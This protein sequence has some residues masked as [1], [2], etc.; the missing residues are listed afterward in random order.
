[1]VFVLENNGMAVSMP[2]RD[3]T[4][5][6]ELVSRATG[7]GMAGVRVDG[8]DV[9]AVYETATRA[10]AD[11]RQGNG[12]T[13]IESVIDRWEGHA[14]G[15]K[16]LRAKQ[17]L[18]RARNRDGGRELKARLLVT[19]ALTE[20]Q[21]AANESECRDEVSSAGEEFTPAQSARPEPQPFTEAMAEHLALAR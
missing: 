17:D 5:A 16:E 7:Y 3:A 20:A 14:V 4:A 19:G 6:R 9:L 8:Q 11:A 10:I 21:T 12:P 1:M 2:T 15:I 13:L 18:D